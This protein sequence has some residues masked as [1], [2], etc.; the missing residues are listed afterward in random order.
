MIL[1]DVTFNVFTK[2]IE[3]VFILPFDASMTSILLEILRNSNI[4]A[5]CKDVSFAIILPVVIELKV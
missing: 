5:S 4:E 3:E 2:I 1:F